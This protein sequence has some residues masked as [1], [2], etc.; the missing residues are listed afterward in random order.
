MARRPRFWEPLA[1]GLLELWGRFS[2]ALPR[3]LA[4]AQ[5]RLLG[6]LAALTQGGKLERRLA[7]HHRSMFGEPPAS[8]RRFM[9]AVFR[10]YGQLV[11][12]FL[13]LPL[14]DR[15]SLAGIV[16]LSDWDRVKAKVEGRGDGV[17][18]LIGAGHFGNWEMAAT[19]ITLLSERPMFGVVR[20]QDFPRLDAWFTGRRE[21]CGMKVLTKWNV[22]LELRKRLSE[23]ANIGLLVDQHSSSKSA[24]WVR[25]GERLAATVPS[26]A[27]LHL[28]TR[29]PILVGTVIR[30]RSGY[31]ALACDLIE[32]DP[33][34][35]RTEA[36]TRAILERI[37]AAIVRALRR[38]PEQYLWTHRRWREP[39]PEVLERERQ[40]P[41]E[42]P[43]YA[44]PPEASS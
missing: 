44:L 2:C 1:V 40:R 13:R 24:L 32:H 41:S 39:P 42:P 28:R 23:G 14:L 31:A 35:P 21:R 16:D 36:T 3:S 4:L 27:Q 12:E 6:E 25:Y 29:A 11:I 18:L 7:D 34:A 30:K 37:N 22:M 9:R 5:G 10:H 8:P 20:P 26:M 43:H 19:V 33:E 38:Y 17:G 15:A